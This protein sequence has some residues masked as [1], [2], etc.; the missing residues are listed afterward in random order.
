MEVGVF[1]SRKCYSGG[2]YRDL[3]IDKARFM[4]YMDILDL[5]RLD[6][7]IDDKLMDIFRGS[8]SDFI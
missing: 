6:Y 4:G 5:G 1:L 7:A 8:Q 2:I 3:L